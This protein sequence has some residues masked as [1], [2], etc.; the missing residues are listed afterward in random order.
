MQDDRPLYEN[1]AA[2]LDRLPAGFPRTPTGVEMRIL[3][4]L[5]SHEEAALAP[6]LGMKPELPEEIAARTGMAVEEIAPRLET[7]SRR[8]LIY[9]VHLAGRDRYMAAQFLIGIWEFHVNDLDPDLIRDMNEY[10]PYFFKEQI[11]LKT[12]Q[13][14][15][16]PV[17]RS[18]PSEQAVMPFDEARG[19]VAEQEKIVLA[20]CICRKEHAIAGN[21]CGR[22]LETCLVF[23]SGADYY[24]GNGLG[25]RITREE[26]LD[27]LQAAEDDAMV[28]QPSNSRKV[29]N[30]C[31]C[32]GCCCQSLKNL[33]KLPDPARYVASNYHALVD[34]AL[35]S[36]CGLCAERCQMDAVRLGDGI[37]CID[38][39]RCIGCGLC[40]PTCP[41]QAARLVR[42]PEGE[43]A[44]P[45]SDSRDRLRR[46][47]AERLKR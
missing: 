16:I 40:V 19:I 37:A 31:V 17:S 24:E 15:T 5:F 6:L 41:E 34:E 11:R 28:L 26:A 10:I 38:R 12:P 20:P 36:G 44:T 9:R 35:C 18:L 1:L 32:C 43:F 42:K 21:A 13:L 33:R 30:I 47:A 25:R 4:R 45:P 29:S 2:H 7:M 3:R 8:G 22:P 14:R 39:N 46:I 27:I 23:G